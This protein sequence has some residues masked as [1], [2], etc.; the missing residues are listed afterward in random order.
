MDDEFSVITGIFLEN[1]PFGYQ[2]NI[3]DFSKT[4]I[5]PEKNFLLKRHSE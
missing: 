1:H 5:L 4:F 3:T 2:K